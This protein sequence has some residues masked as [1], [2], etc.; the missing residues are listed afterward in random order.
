M[1]SIEGKEGEEKIPLREEEDPPPNKQEKPSKRKKKKKKRQ[2]SEADSGEP[3]LEVADA[4]QEAKAGEPTNQATSGEDDRGAD[5]RKGEAARG[6]QEDKR[7]VADLTVPALAQPQAQE[8]RDRAP[9]RGD[10]SSGC[11]RLGRG[12]VDGWARLRV[13]KKKKK[14]EPTRPAL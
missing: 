11:S 4:D 13:K 3:L 9:H 2:G 7:S 6:D 10:G 1:P 5:K 8:I 14:N 12:W